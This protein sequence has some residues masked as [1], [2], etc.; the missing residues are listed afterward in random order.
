MLSP[1]PAAS[2]ALR[3]LDG[4]GRIVDR[5]NGKVVFGGLTPLPDQV[6]PHAPPSFQVEFLAHESRA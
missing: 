4:G 1:G 3:A 5:F 2:N 6:P